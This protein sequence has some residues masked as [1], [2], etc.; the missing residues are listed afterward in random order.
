MR[1]QRLQPSPA[2]SPLRIPNEAPRRCPGGRWGGTCG[3]GPH[4]TRGNFASFIS[5]LARSAL[6]R[7]G[8]RLPRLWGQPHRGTSGRAGRAPRSANPPFTRN[9]CLLCFVLTLAE[10]Q[11]TKG[12]CFQS[13]P[14]PVPSSRPPPRFKW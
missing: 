8:H 3:P 12:L 14:V 10:A 4:A 7:R 1:Q 2:P 9:T 5:F 13:R 11:S 6:P